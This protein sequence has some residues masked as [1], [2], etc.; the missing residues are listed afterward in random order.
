MKYVGG[1]NTLAY[2]VE[3]AYA[4]NFNYFHYDFDTGKYLNEAKFPINIMLKLFSL[5][6]FAFSLFNLGHRFFLFALEKCLWFSLPIL[7][8]I[9]RRIIAFFPF[10]FETGFFFLQPLTKSWNISTQQFFFLDFN[11]WFS[12]ISVIW[13]I[14]RPRIESQ[15]RFSY[16]HL[17]PILDMCQKV[18]MPNKMVKYSNMKMHSN[19][20]KLVPFSCYIQSH[21][22]IVD[23]LY[24]MNVCRFLVAEN[25]RMKRNFMPHEWNVDKINIVPRVWVTAIS[26]LSAF[27][28]AFFHYFLDSVFLL[29]HDLKYPTRAVHHSSFNWFY[30]D[31]KT[32]Q[33]NIPTP[34]K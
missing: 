17:V 6:A 30:V 9:F 23:L 10:P 4:E 34:T 2:Y 26:K 27:I 20:W 24:T 8:A 1:W 33:R 16:F 3:R 5:L 11:R 29:A 32:N 31:C 12:S 21:E 13:S 14:S 15:C 25:L 7:C 19:L 28:S 22:N 18:C